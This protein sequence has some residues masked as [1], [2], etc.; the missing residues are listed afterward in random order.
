MHADLN[1]NAS[2]LLSYKH[3]REYADETD[4]PEAISELEMPCSAYPML[5]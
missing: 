4:S 3:V 5:L 1:G 2:K